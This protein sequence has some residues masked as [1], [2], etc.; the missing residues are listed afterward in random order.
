M[1]ATFHDEPEFDEW[2]DAV[3]AARAFERE[4]DYD[5]RWYVVEILDSRWCVTEV[6]P[7]G[8]EWYDSDGNRHGER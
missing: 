8:G 7:C 1:T 5:K 2:G 4:A 6:E 3:D